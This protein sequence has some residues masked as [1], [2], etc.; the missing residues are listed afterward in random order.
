MP[1]SGV[2][3]KQRFVEAIRRRAVDDRYIDRNEER[4]ILQ[5]ALQLGISRDDAHADLAR[6]CGESGYLL[7]TDI[8]R[9]IQG[10]I[11]DT[12]GKDGRIGRRG[13]EQLVSEARDAVQGRQADREVRRLVVTAIEDTPT[14]RVRTGWLRNWFKAEKKLLGMA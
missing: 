3:I 9:Q 2:D 10:R 8:F 4:E 7:E 11:A 5:I 13:F 12:A 1:M 14:A 6:V